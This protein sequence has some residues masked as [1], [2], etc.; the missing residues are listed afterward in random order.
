MNGF[1]FGII[2]GAAITAFAFKAKEIIKWYRETF[3]L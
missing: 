2:V 1:F 3:D